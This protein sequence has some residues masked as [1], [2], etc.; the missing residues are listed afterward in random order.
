MANTG[1][2]CRKKKIKCDGKQ[3]CLHCQGSKAECVFTF[4]EKKRAQPKGAK[5]IEGLENRLHRMEHLLRLS[6]LLGENEVSQTDLGLLEQRLSDRARSARNSGSPMSDHRKSMVESMTGRSRSAGGTPPQRE[7]TP[8]PKEEA[9]TGKDLKEMSKNMFADDLKQCREMAEEGDKASV[10]NL[11][12]M[13]DSLITN[14]Q[15]ETRYIG[16]SSGVSIFSPKG[17]KW[18]TEKTGDA[19]FAQMFA[20]AAPETWYHWRV[21]LGK[22][23]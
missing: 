11:A 23:Y 9:D 15:G 14:N 1:P 5:Y 20:S 18:V 3:P 19:S 16:S 12:E 8:S 13:M 4:T 7:L 21:I 22:L 17:I 6:G 2:Q 10:D